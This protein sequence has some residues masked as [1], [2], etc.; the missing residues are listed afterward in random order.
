MRRSALAVGVGLLFV[1]GLGL[2]LIGCKPSSSEGQGK[3]AEE[4]KTTPSETAL[5]ESQALLL[6]A[7]QAAAYEGLEIT[8]LSL[9]RATEFSKTPPEGQGYAVLRFKVRNTGAEEKSSMVGGDLQWAETASGRRNGP[10]SYTGVPTESSM[11]F[12][13]APGAEAVYEEVYL[14]PKELAEVE[15]H[16]VPGLDPKEKARWMMKID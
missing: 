7:G 4:P 5:A 2:G 10:E 8:L 1:A 12:R 13:L 11:D 16:Y 3:P 14:I 6:R 15:L 9:T